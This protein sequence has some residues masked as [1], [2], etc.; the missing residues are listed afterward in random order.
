[1]ICIETCKDVSTDLLSAIKDLYFSTHP[2]YLNF[3]LAFIIDDVDYFLQAQRLS[4]TSKSIFFCGSVYH[5]S[6]ALLSNK[7]YF[8]YFICCC[9]E[10]QV[11]GDVLVTI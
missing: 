6:V 2:K 10:T 5:L 3:S 1:M 7:I 11:S 4:S 8:S 9:G